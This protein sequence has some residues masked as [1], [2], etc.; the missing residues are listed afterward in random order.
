MPPPVMG[1]AVGTEVISAAFRAAGVEV[2]HVNTQD[3]RTVFN[4]GVFDARNVA[5]GLLHAAQTAWKALRHSVRLVYVPISQNRWGYARDASLIIIARMLRKPVVV[6]LRGANLQEFFHTSS[7]VERALIR[8]TLRPVALAIA[9][10]PGLRG[11]FDGLVPPE[12]IQVLE[13]AIPDPWPN[14]VEHLQMARSDRVAGEMLHLLY[15]ANDFET[16]GA[17]VAVEA[18]TAPELENAQLRL[19]GAPPTAVMRALE[20]R[21]E[22]LGVRSRVELLGGLVGAQ[23]LR[24]YE[25]ADIF[26]YPTQNDGQPLVV[27][28]AMAAALPI[29][30]T[31]QGG[32]PDTVA[33]TAVVVERAD[34]SSFRTALAKLAGDVDERKR[35]G[36]AARARF[37]AR[38]T[39]EHFQQRFEAVFSELAGL[40]F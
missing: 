17:H 2:V 30:T 26:V 20:D 31:T 18:L 6:H 23:K 36:A 40:A 11:V 1:P 32:I 12:R 38:Y 21:A 3:R 13:N 7:P 8:S 34:P 5:L 9:L 15:V 10:T 24:Q 19:I 39:P 4:V 14:G 27:L 33:E 22:R 25:W 35:L 28:E 29:V 37:L 16:K